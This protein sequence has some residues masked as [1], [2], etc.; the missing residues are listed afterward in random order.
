LLII[1]IRN[2][3][4]SMPQTAYLSL[5]IIV[6]NIIFSYKGFKNQ[7]FFEGYLFEVDKILVQKD[8]KRLITSGFLHNDW[9]HLIFNMYSLYVFS[10]SVERYLGSGAF[11]LIYF[12]S[13]IG[14]NLLSLFIHR[15][16]ANYRAVGAS[17]AVS[18]VIFAA[19]A[20]FPGIEVGMFPLPFYIWGW[21]YGLA[22]VLYSIYG[23]GTRRGNIGHDAHLGGALTGVLAAVIV[24][25]SSVVEYWLT[26][27]IITLPCLIFLYLIYT[28]P[29]L[30]LLDN[31]FSKKHK[32]KLSIDQQYNAARKNRQQELDAILEKIHRKG[33]NSLTPVEKEKLEA[34]S[35]Q[36]L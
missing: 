29:H 33:I 16:H 34:Y 19:I 15:N 17:G 8:Y 2:L 36:E 31:P 25:P 23:I 30:L 11:L 1:V 26:I 12:A 14:G 4:T 10:G 28:R 27:L 32:P 35:K 6:A 7:S 20:V 5:I 24:S 18:G 21:L 9:M 3:K 13:L 22:Y